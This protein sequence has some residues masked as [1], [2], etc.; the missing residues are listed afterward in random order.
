MVE[1]P[2]GALTA[3]L[4]SVVSSLLVGLVT[5]VVTVRLA[6][7]RFYSEKWWERKSAAYTEILES[8]HHLREHADTHFEFELRG[9]ELP[10]EGKARL[11]KNLQK[12]MADL[13]LRRDVGS[14]VISEEATKLLNALLVELEKSTQENTFFEYLDHRVA[15]IDKFLPEMRRIAR[16]D[17]SLPGKSPEAESPTPAPAPQAKG[18]AQ[19]MQ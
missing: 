12:A 8:T 13:R 4:L 16:Q 9:R 3:A 18:S 5:A 11:E 7:R 6:L 17:L 15:A 10:P 2:E 14:F 19:G 1:I